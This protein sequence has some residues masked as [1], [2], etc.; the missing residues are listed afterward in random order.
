[1]RTSMSMRMCIS[2][3]VTWWTWTAVR[4]RQVELHIHGPQL[5]RTWTL[6]CRLAQTGS[7]VFMRSVFLVVVW[8]FVNNIQLS[9]LSDKARA[10]LGSWLTIFKATRSVPVPVPAPVSASIYPPWYRAERLFRST[11]RKFG[12]R[13][14]ERSVVLEWYLTASVISSLN[15]SLSLSLSR[16]SRLFVRLFIL[17]KRELV[18]GKLDELSS[19]CS[20]TDLFDSCTKRASGNREASVWGFRAPA[21]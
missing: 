15:L 11:L 18:W 16:V 1:M 3:L 5:R 21:Q 19:V 13:V 20:T 12:M 6:S 9:C 4:K 10:W 17:L 7:L 8:C 2:S 14:G